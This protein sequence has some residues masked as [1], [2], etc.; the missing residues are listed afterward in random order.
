MY[1]VMRAISAIPTSTD[2]M[3]DLQCG[4][5]EDIYLTG[6]KQEGIS[7]WQNQW[8]FLT[9]EK[10]ELYSQLRDKYGGN[11]DPKLDPKGIV[12]NKMMGLLL[13]MPSTGN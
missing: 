6:K 4:R 7:H 3:I 12:R 9:K 5:I 10:P 2:A 11:M 13:D 1:C 8:E